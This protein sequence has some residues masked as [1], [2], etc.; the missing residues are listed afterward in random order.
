MRREVLGCLVFC[1]WEKR[2]IDEVKLVII[3]IMII[4]MIII[5]KHFLIYTVRV[6]LAYMTEAC[7]RSSLETWA[8]KLTRA[9]DKKK[10]S[11]NQ[12]H[13]FK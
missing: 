7:L 11:I 13:A 5:I 3:I 8:P 10:C 2:F 6:T 9:K 4:E 1:V 12:K